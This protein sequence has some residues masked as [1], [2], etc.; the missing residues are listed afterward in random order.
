MQYAIGL[1]IGGTNT[2]IGLVNSSARIVDQR[3]LKTNTT[4]GFEHFI[5]V[6]VNEIDSLME[7][8]G[9]K[10]NRL[11]GIGIGCTGPVDPISGVIM[12][13]FT[14]PGWGGNNLIEPFQSLIERPVVLENNTDMAAFG[15][16]ILD[17]QRPASLLLLTFGTGVGGGVILKGRIYR[18]ANGEHPE[19]GHI[20]VR[21][22]GAEC[23]CGIKG[24]LEMVASG[25]AI[26]KAAKT[27]G[28]SSASDVFREA[29]TGNYRAKAILNEI[30]DCIQTALW[31][32]LHTFMPETIILGGGVMDGNFESLF[33]QLEKVLISAKMVP[34]NY[35]VLR[36]GF[37]KNDAGI[38]GAAMLSLNQ[39]NTLTI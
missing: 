39:D 32:I 16:Y 29:I 7:G 33:P 30:I 19:I 12:T 5:K 8:N 2:S 9:I 26:T 6:L 22:E 36:K 3:R 13:D 20:P 37:P 14:L 31:T 15:E 35:V 21:R 34:Q 38:I 23:Y 17:S 10:K 25:T 1:I 18:G 11:L 24:C 27:I 28:L 4:F